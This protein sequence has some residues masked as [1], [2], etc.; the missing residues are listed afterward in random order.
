VITPWPEQP[1]QLEQS[2]RAT[3][4]RLGDVEVVCLEH[5]GSPTVAD[6][7][8]AGEALPWRKWLSMSS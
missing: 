5:V 4:A 2:N 3:I 8:R 6:L 7:A 1:S